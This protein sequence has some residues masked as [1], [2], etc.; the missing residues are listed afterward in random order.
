MDP[1]ILTFRVS[2][3]LNGTL[4]FLSLAIIT[5]APPVVTT[6]LAFNGFIIYLLL[7]PGKLPKGIRI[8]L[9]NTLISLI[10]HCTLGLIIGA[11]YVSENDCWRSIFR[12]FKLD[13]YNGSYFYLN[14]SNKELK[15]YIYDCNQSAYSKRRAYSAVFLLG[16]P[17][18][19]TVRMLFMAFY[20]ILIYISVKYLFHK[21]KIWIVVIGCIAAWL[22][23]VI[24]NLGSLLLYFYY[25]FAV[26]YNIH[27]IACIYSL[28]IPSVI[29]IPTFAISIVLPILTLKF[30]NKNTVIEN[31]KEGRVLNT[32]KRAMTKLAI[33]LLISN[34]LALLGHVIPFVTIVAL[35]LSATASQVGPWTVFVISILLSVASLFSTP[36]L[37]L[38]FLKDVRQ[39]AKRLL[40]CVCKHYLCSKWSGTLSERLDT[41]QII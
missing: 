17:V 26:S 5:A 35:V 12:N 19:V 36:I 10:L 21:I 34:S 25:P 38:I 39:N 30:I 27:Y 2:A 1:D 14:S 7:I 41:P 11:V 32:F 13:I 33:F 23:A 18:S 29:A 31:S 15:S 20:T 37:Y 9:I 6:V 40:C 22:V 16:L 28:V 24:L 3:A 8:L 4:D